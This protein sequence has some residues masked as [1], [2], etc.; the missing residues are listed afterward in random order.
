MK[1]LY[2]FVAGKEIKWSKFKRESHISYLI[3]GLGRLPEGYTGL[4]AS[5]S[6]LCFW[7]L[8][9]LAMLD[10]PF[11]PELCDSAIDKI[12]R[13]QNDTG[14]FG[15]GPGQIS[16][17]GT[18]YSAVHSLFLMGGERAYSVIK[19]DQLYSWFLSLKQ[20]D[21]SFQMSKGG[22]I[23][24]RASYCV[25]ACASLLNLMTPELTSGM[26]AFIARCQGFDGGLGCYPGSESHGG[27]TF[28]G[29]AALA[30]LGESELI[31]IPSVI[32]W[33]VDRQLLKEGGFQGRPNKLVDGCYSF[34]TGAIFPILS[35]W[36]SNDPVELYDR[37]AL[38]KYIVLACQAPSGGLRDKP[39]K[40]S[41]YY[42]TCYVLSGLSI[43]QHA[44]KFTA[45]EDPTLISQ[46][47]GLM[48][49]YW[50]ATPYTPL[51]SVPEEHGCLMVSLILYLFNP[52]FRFQRI[53]YSTS[54]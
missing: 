13:L 2:K 9:S 31:D 43:A 51:D 33:T 29:V 15:G 24:I 50:Q 54:Q 7:I 23:D 25:L 40:P 49:Y 48:G 19:K 18:T 41:D 27:Y 4:V 42:H 36:I 52:F 21:G 16:H 11:S 34:W 30:L 38:K 35:S 32:K 53:L 47:P 28:C 6:W 46:T 44:Y 12:T 1:L 37:E 14:G 8:Q 39:G 5:Q 10:Y 22:E 3:E 20:K 17:L 45:P 26:G